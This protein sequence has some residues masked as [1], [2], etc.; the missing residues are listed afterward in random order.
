MRR[1]VS[2][3]ILWSVGHGVSTSHVRCKDVRHVPTLI[4][5]VKNWKPNTSFSKPSFTNS[6]LHFMLMEEK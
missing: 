5:N 2:S 3:A 4:M 1:R 6:Y